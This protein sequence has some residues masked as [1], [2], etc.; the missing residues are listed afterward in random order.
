MTDFALRLPPQKSSLDRLG[1]LDRDSQDK[2]AQ[3]LLNA[4]WVCDEDGELPDR[5]SHVIR[6][7]VAHARFEEDPVTEERREEARRRSVA[8]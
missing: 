6:S 2:L 5:I 4:L 1:R 8:S 3:E 7:W